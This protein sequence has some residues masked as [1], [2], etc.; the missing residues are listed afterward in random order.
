MVIKNITSPLVLDKATVATRLGYHN[1]VP[2]L[3]VTELI[4]RQIDA[5]LNLIHPVYSYHF[6]RLENLT[7]PDFSLEGHLSFSSKTVSYVLSGCQ[8]VAV[9]LA[10]I[11]RDIDI[12]ITHL[13]SDRQTMAGTILDMISSIAIVQTLS[14]LRADVRETAENQGL[15]TTRHY[16]PGYCDWDIR[17]QRILFPV[18]DSAALE[19]HLNEACMMIPRKSV[20][21]V[22]GIGIL[23][24]NKKPPCVLF[25]QKSATCEYRNM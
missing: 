7:A 25:C 21:G 5:A 11:G 4:D 24:K 15:Q 16:A 22:I 23:D 10:T 12:E 1:R 6:K 8:S 20:S 13:M 18:L 14:Q 9:Y 17:Q 19:V 3:M 2:P